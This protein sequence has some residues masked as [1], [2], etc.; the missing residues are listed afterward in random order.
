MSMTEYAGSMYMDTLNYQTSDAPAPAGAYAQAA[1]RGGIIAIAGQVGVNP[2][3]GQIVPG[4]EGQIRQA[5]NN[6][7]AVLEAAGSHLGEVIQTRV[8]LDDPALFSLFNGVY[9]EYMP[10]SGVPARAT[11]CAALTHPDL[12]FEIEALAVR[13]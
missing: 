7:V 4:A 5:M 3:T 12:V 1:E 8:Y 2:E 9:A 10:E 11:V 13:L 6:L